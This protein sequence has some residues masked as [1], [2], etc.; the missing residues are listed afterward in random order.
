MIPLRWVTIGGD[1]SPKVFIKRLFALVVMLAASTCLADECG[2]W[3][4]AS[5]IEKLEAPIEAARANVLQ[6][7]Q[8]LNQETKN[9][10]DAGAVAQ[11]DRVQLEQN[12]VLSSYD[13]V[14]GVVKY[15]D[16][17]LLLTQ[18]KDVMIDS[19]DRVFVEAFLSSTAVSA[20]KASRLAQERVNQSLVRIAR[21]GVVLDVSKLR[22]SV[23]NALKALE[24]CS[25]PDKAR[26]RNTL[27]KN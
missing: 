24:N 18:V 20:A 27:R 26:L 6:H 3:L 13:G 5:R 14:D 1:V 7:M 12:Q 16:Q 10:L 23:S 15:L 9:L 8:S 2:K 11:A 19:R 25:L 4:T 17:A 21:P 22:D